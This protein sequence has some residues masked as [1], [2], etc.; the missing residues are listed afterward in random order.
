MVT[1]HFVPFH[2]IADLSSAKRINKLLTIVKQEKIVLLEGQLKKEEE[3][4]LIEITMEEIGDK[5]KGIELAV[6]YPEKSN[7]DII[8]RLRFDI[9]RFL[10]GNRQGFTIVGP[11]SIVKRVKQNPGSI[12]LLT[13]DKRRKR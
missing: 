6:I 3:A 13:Q 4:D 2:E 5:F 10:V 9:A 11:A 7:M 12:E 1:F 8:K